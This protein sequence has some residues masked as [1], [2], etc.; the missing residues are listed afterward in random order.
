MGDKDP[1]KLRVSSH[2]AMKK[3]EEQLNAVIA[4]FSSDAAQVKDASRVVSMCLHTLIDKVGS[5]SSIHTCSS[6]GGLFWL[7]KPAQLTYLVAHS[8]S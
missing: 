1:K 4:E 3:S 6:S 2:E 7:R 5:R 8:H